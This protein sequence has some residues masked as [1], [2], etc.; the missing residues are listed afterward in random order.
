M[1]STVTVD[2]LARFEEIMG[3]I[4]ELAEE[5]Y[6]I[7]RRA[8]NDITTER[9]RSYWYP[10]IVTNI[11]HDHDY[12]TREMFTM[13]DTWHEL[14]GYVIDG[15]EHDPDEQSEEFVGDLVTEE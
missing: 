15:D 6:R 12:M 2:D 9:A 8:G 10:H 3:E 11:N 7:T 14:E 1:K 5:A 13:E 4:K